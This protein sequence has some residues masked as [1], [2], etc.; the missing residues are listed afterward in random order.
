VLASGHTDRPPCSL[1]G[2][3]FLY[4]RDLRQVYRVES[5]VGLAGSDGNHHVL[6]LQLLYR[7]VVGKTIILLRC[8]CR[9]QRRYRKNLG[10]VTQASSRLHHSVDDYDYPS[11]LVL[12]GD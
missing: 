4:R 7:F 3:L 2:T 9:F 8:R 5:L 11:R 12:V 10:P 1:Q 6:Q